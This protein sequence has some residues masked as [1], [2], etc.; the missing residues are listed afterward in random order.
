MDYDMPL[1]TTPRFPVCD[2]TSVF[3]VYAEDDGSY[4]VYQEDGD[5]SDP[6]LW[7][8]TPCR[9]FPTLDQAREWADSERAM[10]VE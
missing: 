3:V 4:V 8:I 6:E 2:H 9:S 1:Y 5:D 7:N 10:I